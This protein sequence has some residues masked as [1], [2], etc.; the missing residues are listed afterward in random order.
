VGEET[1]ITG[2][3]R[4][5]LAVADG[6]MNEPFRRW[7]QTLATWNQ[8]SPLRFERLAFGDDGAERFDW[9]A[10]E[11]IQVQVLGPFLTDAG[12]QAGPQVPARA[13]RRAAAGSRV[14]LVGAVARRWAQRLAHHQRP[15][16]RAAFELRPVS[17]PLTGDL[18]D[19][20]GRVLT[21]AHNRGDLNVRAEVLKVAAPRLR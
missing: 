5:L 14:D 13:A 19:E 16:G 12:A 21:R 3:E 20:A 17:L 1:V 7:K 11:D 9:L 15:L 6:E 18:N 2:L 8:R 10:E 4:D